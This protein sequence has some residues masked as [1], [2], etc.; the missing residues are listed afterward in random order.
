[1]RQKAGKKKRLLEEDN[2]ECLKCKVPLMED[3]EEVDGQL[4][5]KCPVCQD[6][7]YPSSEDDG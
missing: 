6:K 2:K 5:L 3:I 7:K 4:V 1:M